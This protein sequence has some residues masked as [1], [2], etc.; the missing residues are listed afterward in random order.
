MVTTSSARFT[1]VTR[2]PA[3]L[4]F[5]S[6][7]KI[8][9]GR[10]GVGRGVGLSGIGLC[11]GRLVGLRGIHNRHVSCRLWFGGRL[12]FLSTL[13]SLGFWCLMIVFVVQT[14]FLGVLRGACGL[15]SCSLGLCWLSRP[16]DRGL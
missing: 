10:G 5:L 13:S 2:H 14:S 3:S 11:L 9:R 16:W 1:H 8:C 4:D 12:G 6:R 7:G 15:G